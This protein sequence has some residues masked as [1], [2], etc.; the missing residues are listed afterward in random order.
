MEGLFSVL[1]FCC[2]IWNT[3]LLDASKTRMNELLRAWM[4]NIISIFQVDPFYTTITKQDNKQ[5][6]NALY[7]QSCRGTRC[8]EFKMVV[9]VS[10]VPELIKHTTN[11]VNHKIVKVMVKEDL[12]P[13]KFIVSR[14]E[15]VNPCFVIT[16]ADPLIRGAWPSSIQHPTTL[17]FP[18]SPHPSPL[19][20]EIQS[21]IQLVYWKG[22]EQARCENIYISRNVLTTGQLLHLDS[23][24]TMVVFDLYG[25][26]PSNKLR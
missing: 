13:I 24:E 15:K 20:T 22:W 7:L 2:H 6:K 17:P 8:L 12:G 16:D 19:S 1:Q 21:E 3:S 26:V 11:T 23:E 10:P 25:N 14:K 4:E 5:S 18:P 9:C